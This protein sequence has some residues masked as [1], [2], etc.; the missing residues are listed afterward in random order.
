MSEDSDSNHFVLVLIGM[1][2]WMII[3]TCS[4]CDNSQK[5]SNEAELT[6]VRVVVLE[7]KVDTLIQEV[8]ALNTDSMQKP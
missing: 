2:M 1:F 8:R 3:G 6:H 7:S 5:A 4:S